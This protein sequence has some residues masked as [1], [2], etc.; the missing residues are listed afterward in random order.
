MNYL[1]WL[2]SNHS[3]IAP[4][5]VYRLEPLVPSQKDIFI[6]LYLKIAFHKDF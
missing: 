3:L 4:S 5:Q 6:K 2:G 1:P